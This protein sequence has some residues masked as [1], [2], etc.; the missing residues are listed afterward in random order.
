[1]FVCGCAGPSAIR[2]PVSVDG[3]LQPHQV[4]EI[5]FFPQEAYQCGPAALA[6]TLAWSGLAVTPDDLVP[7]AFTASKKGSLQS[8]M[9]ASVRRRNRI[10]YLLDG[11]Q[12]LIAEIAAGHPVVVL[13]N[14]GLQWYPVWHYA[15]VIGWGDDGRVL[16]H[17]GTTP[18]KTTP[19]KTFERTWA[20]SDFWGLLVLPPSRLPATANEVDYVKAV[21]HLERLES[22]PAAHQAYEA[23]LER[24]PDS[25]PA[26]VGIG[27]CLYRMGDL[28]LA[29]RHYQAAGKRFPREGVVFNNLAQVLLAQGRRG[30]ALD[31]AIYAIE[32]GGPLKNHFEET[33]EEIRKSK[34]DTLDNRHGQQPKK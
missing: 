18:A 7:E 25:L 1:M 20:R 22:W 24:W 26:T 16:L 13:Q 4:A 33:L 30:E 9:I 28:A 12:A 21:S 34:P 5:P 2:L 23:A 32:C 29:E 3:Y 10:A 11:P 31:A 17:S 6:M 27:V 14:L 19:L 15:V 8:A